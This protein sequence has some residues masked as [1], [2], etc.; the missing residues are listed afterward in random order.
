MFAEVWLTIC[1]GRPFLRARSLAGS[2]SMSAA[3]QAMRFSVDRMCH[4]TT[5]TNQHRT[6]E[7]PEEDLN[8]NRML[9]LTGQDLNNSRGAYTTHYLPKWT[10]SSTR[11]R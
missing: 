1:S 8:Q 3:P 9:E 5:R 10:S 6:P 2:Q 4:M 11:K 7:L